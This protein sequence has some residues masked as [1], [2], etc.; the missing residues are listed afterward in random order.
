MRRSRIGIF[1]DVKNVY[2]QSSSFGKMMSLLTGYFN[3]N[4]EVL[5]NPKDILHGWRKKSSISNDQ[6][7][8]LF[9]TQTL[10][11]MYFK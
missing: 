5:T 11:L 8:I 9:S 7:V 4:I 1:C 6:F 10:A 2:G 3:W